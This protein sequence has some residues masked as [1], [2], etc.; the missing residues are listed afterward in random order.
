[1]VEAAR[2]IEAGPTG[3]YQASAAELEAV[4]RGLDDARA[5]RF[6]ERQ[7]IR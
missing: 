2:G 1:L 5:G 7:Y 3:V 6:A 4:D